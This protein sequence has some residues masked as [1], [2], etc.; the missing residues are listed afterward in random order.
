MATDFLL[1][2]TEARDLPAIAAI[3]ADAVLTTTASY[4]LEPPTVE[5]MTRRWR[6]VVDKAYPHL[7]AMRGNE[8][9]G[10]A[11]AGP[12]HQRP[13]YRFS[14]EDSIYLAPASRGAGLGRALLTEL[15]RICEEKGF[16]QMI[17]VI[18]GG[19]WQPASVG[20]HR[21]LG[22]R[23]IGIVEG[24]GFKHGRWLDTILMQRPLGPGNSTLP[25]GS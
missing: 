12:Y 23:E 8:V 3:Y 6:G 9:L 20:L 13:G 4:E 7:V 24:S 21:A 22:F 1:R 14:V 5:E 15:V 25:E 16:R 10:Y 11:Y 18:G 17:A 2:P 19:T